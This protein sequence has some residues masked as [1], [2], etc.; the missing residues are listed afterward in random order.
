MGADAMTAAELRQSFLSFFTER[1]HATIASSSLL[2]KG[3]PSLLFTNA[4]M[5]QFKSVFMGQ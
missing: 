5:N 3:D 2:I 1:G 4:G